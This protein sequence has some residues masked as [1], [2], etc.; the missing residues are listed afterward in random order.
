MSTGMYFQIISNLSLHGTKWPNLALQSVCLFPSLTY[1]LPSCLCIWPCPCTL[2]LWT[3][4]CSPIFLPN[5]AL[6]VGPGGHSSAQTGGTG[7]CLRLS[8][9]VI[10]AAVPL[11]SEVF[12]DWDLPDLDQGFFFFFWSATEIWNMSHK[13]RILLN[14]FLKVSKWNS[15]L[16]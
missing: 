2:H 6:S 3:L 1:L 9:F 5:S 4:S 13:H 14:L 10:S 12:T 7:P 11:S 16:L 8:L 15:S